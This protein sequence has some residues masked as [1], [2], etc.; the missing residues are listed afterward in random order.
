MLAFCVLMEVVDEN[1]NMHRS[2]DVTPSVIN[3]WITG[4]TEEASAIIDSPFVE[5]MSNYLQNRL[6]LCKRSA[7]KEAAGTPVRRR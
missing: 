3:R 4:V 2:P 7:E 6:L 5:N 1:R